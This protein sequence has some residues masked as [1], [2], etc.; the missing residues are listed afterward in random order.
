MSSKGKVLVAM[1]GGIDSS[2]TAMLL[3]EEGYEVIGITMKTWDYA[4]SGG[5]KKET[6]C[7]S[8][9]SINDARTI[10]VNLGFP[11][12]ILD[13]REEF[14]DFIID[15]FVEEYLAG[16][17]PNPCVL[18][19]THIKWEALLKRANMLDCEFIATGHYANVRY[20]N[21]R[22]IISKGLDENKDQSYVLWGL[23]QESLK[24]T[25]FPLGKFTKKEIKQMAID[26]GYEEL[27]KK[28][29]S[30]EICFV[31]DNDYRSFL[32]RR[33]EGLEEKVDGGNFVRTDGTIIGKHRGYPFYTIGQRK[34]LEIAMGEP[35]FV[36]EI[37]PENNT[38][39]LGTKEDLMKKEMKV[40]NVNLVKYEKLP[41]DFTA[42]TKIRYKDPGTLSSVNLRGDKLHILFHD[43]VSGVAPGQSAV[44]YE[45]NDLVGGGFI[46]RN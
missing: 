10:G 45:G 43:D 31:P 34:G 32:K 8:L 21:G 24:R 12:Y 30:Y 2:V 25:R 13:I 28:S 1:S 17:T 3:H 26:R 15:N 41:E 23:S 39:V 38:V 46:D 40:R 37:V 36:T 14:G 35:M 20:E 42:L 29:E 9:D 4:T 5:S 16:R 6:G 22:Y 33:V 18:C 19:N 11:H 27:A 44:M 7:C